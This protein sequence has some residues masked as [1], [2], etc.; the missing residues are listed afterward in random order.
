MSKQFTLGKTERLKSRKSIEQIF[1]VGKKLVTGSFRVLY[2]L[3]SDVLT[4][5]L[6]FGAGVSSKHFKKAVDRN[7][8]KRLM[9]EAW[10]LQKSDLEEMIRSQKQ[11]MHVFCIYTGKALPDYKEV[12]EKLTDVISKL[13]KVCVK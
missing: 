7:R 1:A 8:V 13:V 12:F 4:P 6:A 9:R 3:N 10:R 5:S 11:S 2:V